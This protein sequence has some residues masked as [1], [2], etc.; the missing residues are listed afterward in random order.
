M[1]AATV[2]RRDFGSLLSAACLCLCVS[3]CDGPGR[4]EQ[5]IAGTRSEIEKARIETQ[6]A[7]DALSALDIEERTL[8][9]ILSSRKNTTPGAAVDQDQLEAIK[10]NAA[11]LEK[12]VAK[13]REDLERY[14]SQYR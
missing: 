12:D 10:L 9:A 2:R 1:S 8:R 7:R 5:E 3:A 13:L 4:I 11:V 14:K 6:K